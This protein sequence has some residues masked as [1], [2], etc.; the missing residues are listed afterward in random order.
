M[1]AS[2]DVTGA[3]TA[4]RAAAEAAPG[5]S[6][7]AYNLGLLCKYQSRWD[8]SFAFNRLAASLDPDD[9]AANWNWGIA[10][11]A[12]GRW[13]DARAAWSACGMH[14]PAGDGPPDFG[15]GKTPVRLN[16]DD[17]GEV[18]WSQRLDPARARLIS[19]P[20]P[21]STY[22]WGDIVL[23]DGAQE[24]ERISDGRR[25]PV[26]N[27][28]ARLVPSQFA[29]FI[30]E[31]ATSDES[32]IELLENIAEEEGGAAEN[33]GAQPRSSAARAAMDF[34]TDT[35]TERWSLPTRSAGSRR[36]PVITPTAL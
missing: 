1:S 2:G 3:E 36:S 25:Y 4:Y 31:L 5:W 27:T 18:V 23:T 13:D 28:L 22:W 6:V 26:F 30:V 35:P 33:W 11:T 34:P 14:P 19:I 12:L 10:A 29:T 7:P 21:A 9:E 24:G 17:L 8:E 32:V 15:W 20:L 16:P